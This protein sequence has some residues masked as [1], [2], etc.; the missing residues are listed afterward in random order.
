MPVSV[1]PYTV[2]QLTSE[3]KNLLEGSYP[4]ILL[5][6]EVSNFRPASSGHW[7]F[8]LKDEQAMI[9]A[10]MFRNAQ[11]S[12]RPVNGQMLRVRG[13]LSLYAQRGNYQIICSSI[14]EI[15]EGRILQMLEERKR[16]LAAEGLFDKAHK[17]PLPLFPRRV[18]VLSSESG[19][20]VRDIIRVIRRRASWLNVCVVNIPVQGKGAAGQIVDRLRV[21][22][23]LGDVI[24]LG[25][26]GGSLEDLLAFSDEELV[27]AIHRCQTP[28][29]SAVGH[30]I[31]WSLSDFA[32]DLRAPT[33][34]AAA[35]MLCDNAESFRM[36]ILTAGRI[37]IQAF[38]AMR[39][40]LVLALKPFRPEVLETGFRN[41]L[42]PHQLA[43]D[44][45]REQ[46]IEAMTA[47]LS[48]LRQRSHLAHRELIACDPHT[49]LKRGYAIV[50]DNKREIVSEAGDLQADSDISIT[51]HDGEVSA[52]VTGDSS[53]PEEH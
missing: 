14:E 6:G 20:A 35:E 33:P 48:R 41:C 19:A 38:G 15:G 37:I 51:F 5:E 9:Q 3:I 45:R 32:A 46:L 40:R 12:A 43:L 28:I 52:K 53:G 18:L 11:R 31:D 36:R 1:Q 42:R 17:K 16:R 13:S 50:R 7:Y 25:R 8:S 26:G 49:V 10:V 39:E 47:F 22:E 27:R 23:E 34:S 30:E 21:A 44:D 24:I 29:V 2:S 4:G